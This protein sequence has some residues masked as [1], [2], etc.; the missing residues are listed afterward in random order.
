VTRKETILP[1]RIPCIVFVPCY[2]A[3]DAPRNS[4]NAKEI[5][6]AIF[7]TLL[8]IPVV[9]FCSA[10]ISSLLSSLFISGKAY[11]RPQDLPEEVVFAT[12][13]ISIIACLGFVV[14]VIPLVRIPL[15]VVPCWVSAVAGLI[16]L[17]CLWYGNRLYHG[18]ARSVSDLILMIF[19]IP[20]A[21][22]YTACFAFRFSRA[23][24]PARESLIRPLLWAFGSILVTSAVI[25]LLTVFV[26]GLPLSEMP[27]R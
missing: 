17:G 9:V 24:H 13:T 25:A 15:H 6:K 23:R 18:L 1:L 27:V 10:M 4:M 16:V 11:H 22:C 8:L 3:L 7:L 2:N 5:T 19:L 21:S 14:A 26:G 12:M 20:A